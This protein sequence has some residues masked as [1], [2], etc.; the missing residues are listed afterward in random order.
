VNAGTLNCGLLVEKQLISRISN[1]PI[2]KEIISFGKI[3][4]EKFSLI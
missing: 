1:I 3:G 4:V 2:F